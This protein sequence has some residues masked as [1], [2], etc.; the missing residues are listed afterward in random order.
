MSNQLLPDEK[1]VELDVT[2]YHVGNISALLGNA[3]KKIEVFF[4]NIELSSCLW[5]NCLN[6]ALFS[7]EWT[8]AINI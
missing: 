3:G 8:K 6:H 1:N 7:E 5:H 4:L 2:F